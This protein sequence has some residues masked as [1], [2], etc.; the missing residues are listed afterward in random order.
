MSFVTAAMSPEAVGGRLAT[1][2]IIIMFFQDG[3]TVSMGERPDVRYTA[4][5]L[6][7]CENDQIG[8]GAD[9]CLWDPAGFWLGQSVT[10]FR[11]QP[12]VELKHGRIARRRTVTRFTRHRTLEV[13]HGRIAM[14]TTMG[15]AT[16]RITRVI[17]DHIL[18]GRVYRA[19][20][21]CSAASRTLAPV[22]R[23]I[24]A[25]AKVRALGCGRFYAYSVFC[26]L[27]ASYNCGM[28]AMRRRVTA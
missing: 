10:R 22:A 16:S 25:T 12:A 19:I 27:S 3:L 13:K 26:E 11:R 23:I 2:E 18:T 21:A 1:M 17:P 4:T 8:L 28:R 6:L 15:Y 24:A 9:D 7:T 14:L 5:P 20:A